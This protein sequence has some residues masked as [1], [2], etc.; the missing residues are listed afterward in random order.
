MRSILLLLS[1]IF[2]TTTSCKTSFRISVKEPSVINLPNTAFNFGVTNNANPDGSPDNTLGALLESEKIN[3]NITA[4]EGAVEGI[5]NA[6]GNSVEF[7]GLVLESDSINFGGGPRW[8]YIDSIAKLNNLHGI[9]QLVEMKSVFPVGVFVNI[10]SPLTTN[11]NLKGNLKFNIYIA[12]THETIEEYYVSD[13]ITI[14]KQSLSVQSVLEIAQKKEQYY[15]SL[16]FELGNRAGKLIYPNFIWVNRTFYN[17]GSKALKLAKPMISQGNWDIAE[18][19]LL[20]GVGSVKNKTKGRVLYN[21]ALV[22][23]GQGEIDA[24]IEYAERSAL[25]TG[26]K[27]ANQYL[28]ILRKRKLIIE[29][30]E[31]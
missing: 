24:A 8:D 18:K 6:L 10:S 12:N 28:N 16:G 1:I 27:L 13:F 5:I 23:E 20:Q 29:Q 7:T 11:Q 9:I 19:Q 17:K 14:P 25:E 4:A 30:I 22:K 15:R 21:L 3:G 2:I 26:N 31:D